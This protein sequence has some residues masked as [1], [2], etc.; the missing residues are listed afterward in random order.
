MVL[1]LAVTVICMQKFLLAYIY[2]YFSLSFSKKNATQDICLNFS[3]FLK[4]RY[5]F[6]HLFSFYV[7]QGKKCSR[8]FQYNIYALFSSYSNTHLYIFN[9]IQG[10]WAGKRGGEWLIHTPPGAHPYG[11]NN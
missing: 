5:L 10:I 7:K 11:Y 3:G 1:F 9:P 8:F 6:P 4:H 2:P